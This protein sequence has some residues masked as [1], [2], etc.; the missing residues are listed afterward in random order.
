MKILALGAHPDDIEFGC[1]GTLIKYITRGHQAFLMVLSDGSKGGN[2]Q[3]R[4]REQARS[5]RIIG[6][7]EVH[8]G[9][10]ADTEV[11]CDR[12]LIKKIED[13]I[14]KV[15]PT[16]I[17]APFQDDT[18]QDHRHLATGT[19]TATRYVRN[20]LFYET[21]TTQNFVPTVFVDIDEILD[22]KI[23]TLEAH[24]SQ[25]KKTHI[26]GLSILAIARSAA[27]FRGIQGRAKNAEG[28]VPQRLFV[29]I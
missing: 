2:A 26:E 29:N 5:A 20:V 27:H 14:E 22:K 21:P 25:I 13:I 8:W 17:F 16:L 6:A 19:I 1:G 3:M 11:P 4:R 18:H 12:G 23:A 10:Y 9:G 28:F 15:E 7:E 24:R